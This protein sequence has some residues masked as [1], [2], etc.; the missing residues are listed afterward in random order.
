MNELFKIIPDAFAILHNGGVY[1]QAQLY[2]RAGRVY[3]QASGGYVMLRAQNGTSH[4]KLR[5]DHVEGVDTDMRGDGSPRYDK[6]GRMI[7]LTPVQRA[8]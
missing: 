1:K 6:L 7:L 5:W 2:E 8:A 4:P 3:A